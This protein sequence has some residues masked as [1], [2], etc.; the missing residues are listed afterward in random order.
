MNLDLPYPNVTCS[1]GMMLVTWRAVETHWERHR[2]AK[3]E[4]EEAKIEQEEAKMEQEEM[5]NAHD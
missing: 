3:M 2:Q 4:Q 5:Q 1:C